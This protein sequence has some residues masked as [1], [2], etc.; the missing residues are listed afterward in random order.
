MNKARFKNNL[1]RTKI[2]WVLKSWFKNKPYFIFWKQVFQGHSKVLSSKR[3]WN[4]LST[5]LLSF[6]GA[7]IY[8]VFIILIFESFQHFFPFVIEFDNEATDT[9]LAAIA[10][11]SGVFLGL[12]FTAISSIASSLLLKAHQDVKDYF[13]TSP[14]GL[15]YV[16]TIETTGIV[17]LFYIVAK[18]FGHEIH[19]FGLIFL[20]LLGAYIILRFWKVGS[21]VYNFAQP[22][23]TLPRMMADIVRAIKDVTP[24]GFNWD[25]DFLQNYN[26]RKVSRTLESIKRYVEFGVREIKL[27]EEE[28]TFALHSYAALLQFYAEHKMMI[29]TKSLWYKTKYQYSKWTLADSTQITIALQTG[30]TTA[31][32]IIENRSWFEE[33][34]LDNITTILDGYGKDGNFGALFQGHDI[35]VEVAESYASQFDVDAIKIFI[36][37]FESIGLEVYVVGEN[38]TSTNKEAL[39]FIDSQG[40]LAIAV[41]LGL[42]KYLDATPGN[43]FVEIVQKINWT[44]GIKNVYLSGAPYSTLD[45]LESLSEELSNEIAIEGN[46]VTDQWYRQA[47]SLQ[48]YL[49]SLHTYYEFIKSLHKDYFE[50]KLTKLI[51]TRKFEYAVQLIERWIEFTNKHSRLTYLLKKHLEEAE[52]YKTLHDLPWPDFKMD[53]EIEWVNSQ[54]KTVADKMISLLPVLQIMTSED[55]IPDYFGHALQVGLEACYEACEENTTD[56]FRSIFPIILN[57][58]IAAHQRTRTEVEAWAQEESKVIFSTEPLV[59]IFE[60][61]GFG[62]LYGEL[63]QNPSLGEI[64]REQWDRYLS[65]TENT[66]GVIQFIAAVVEY[67]KGI[68]KIMPQ[69]P[70]RSNWQIRFNHAMSERGLRVFPDIR[71]P[72][73]GDPNHTSVLIRVLSNTGGLN[74]RS[75]EDVFIELYL[76][77]RPDVEGIEF[78][79]EIRESIEREQRR[80]REDNEDENE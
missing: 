53:E 55:D 31:P 20:A 74:M 78:R 50:K 80:Q 65:L 56:R 7:V 70:L 44:G 1:Y 79:N 40:R 8:S 3:D 67:R 57:A 2:F 54:E 28:L 35:F 22:T 5:T 10:S 73:D 45:R 61:S 46:L 47:Y 58:S 42:S 76:A 71:G 66:R 62:I 12:Y 36:K 4:L 52:Q 9:F 51:E 43:S 21:D 33:Q 60:I 39:G 16:Q 26:S 69:A 15:Q 29:P 77:S 64:V 13:F 19:P 24:P 14:L 37:K 49:Y 18:S 41:L 27:K 23:S 17:S 75:A 25:K 72:F 38:D 30:T 63:L 59:N 48:R 34:V 32:K 11:I 6:V 68:F